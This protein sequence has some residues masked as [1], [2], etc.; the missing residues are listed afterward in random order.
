MYSVRQM[1]ILSLKFL[2]LVLYQ[3][4]LE[5]EN[6]FSLIVIIGCKLS[7]Y[8]N[9]YSDIYKTLKCNGH[10]KSDWLLQSPM[11]WYAKVW[12]FTCSC[13]GLVVWHFIGPKSGHWSL[14]VWR[15]KT[16][17]SKQN[18]LKFRNYLHHVMDWKNVPISKIEK[19]RKKSI[20]G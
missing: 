13:W 17:W 16:W 19:R 14:I 11:V 8:L 12:L 6:K 7:N 1:S 20:K 9:I 15:A 18:C 10:S 2:H 4:T 3:A 5:S